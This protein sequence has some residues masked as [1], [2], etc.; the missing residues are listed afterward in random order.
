MLSEIFSASNFGDLVNMLDF[1]VSVLDKNGESLKE[2]GIKI[3]G[4]DIESSCG[5]K[6][7]SNASLYT[8]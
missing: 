6:R 2:P 5:G 4:S 8:N 7:N 1:D 3:V